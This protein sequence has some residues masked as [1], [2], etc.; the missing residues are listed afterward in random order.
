MLRR[1]TILSSLLRGAKKGKGK[2]EDSKV[3]AT[4]DVINIYKN[5]SDP[6][7]KPRSE[8]PD[9]LFP[10]VYEFQMHP[11]EIGTRIY[12][13]EKMELSLREQRRLAK[14]SRRTK[15]I[16]NNH[17][18]ERDIKVDPRRLDLL[19][20]GLPGGEES[21]DDPEDI[22]EPMMKIAMGVPPNIVIAEYSELLK[23]QL[24]LIKKP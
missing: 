15:I 7:L 2:G 3:E 24:G 22:L 16:A 20:L 10:M 11:V 6:E 23:E 8:Y 4:T 5:Q 14:W 13:G 17:S 19:E 18:K 21:E 1:V 9:W 12:R